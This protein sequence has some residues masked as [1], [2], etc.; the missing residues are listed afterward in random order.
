MKAA[1]ELLES[2][3]VH[4]DVIK[5]RQEQFDRA[6]KEY[7]AKVKVLKDI[8]AKIRDGHQYTAG[9]VVKMKL[10]GKV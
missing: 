6:E 3:K 4:K 10:G 5:R 2:C 8:D 1:K 9:D 7:Q